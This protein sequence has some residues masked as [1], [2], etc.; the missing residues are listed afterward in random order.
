MLSTQVMV[1][2]TRVNVVN[3]FIDF[4]GAFMALH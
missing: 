1:I 4:L 2:I 3:T